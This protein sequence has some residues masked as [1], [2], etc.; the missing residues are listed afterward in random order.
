[1]RAAAHSA[2]KLMELGEPEPVGVLN[3][4]DR[5]IGDVQ[6]HFDDRGGHKNVN[7]SCLEGLHNGG[8]LIRF[9]P[10][11]EESQF[12]RRKFLRLQAFRGQDRCFQIECF[13][14]LHQRIHDVGLPPLGDFFPHRLIGPVT[15]LMANDPGLNGSPARR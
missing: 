11:V 1:M 8:L 9:H 12:P 6:P 2:A 10:S 3:H 7:V 5:G 15:R 13:R 14:F 4:H